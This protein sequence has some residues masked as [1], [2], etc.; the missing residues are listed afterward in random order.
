[1][2]DEL[3]KMIHNLFPYGRKE[4]DDTGK[5]KTLKKE[6]WFMLILCG[7]LLVV[8]AIPK[9]HLP[10][11]HKQIGL[12]QNEKIESIE[13]K[14]E[15]MEESESINYTEKMEREVEEVLG[16]MAGVGDIKV[17]ITL[18]ASTE[19]IIEKDQPVNRSHTAEKDSE[20][21]TRSL[22]TVEMGDT[23]VYVKENGQEKPYVVKVIQPQVEGVVV[24][25]QGAGSGSVNR[26]ITEAMQVLFGIEAHKVKVLK[27]KTS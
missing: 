3:G 11:S 13:E 2:S 24:L 8:L 18:M 23:T 26:N 14:K 15:L 5:R 20:G 17:M 27:M 12:E 21:G 25:A 16:Q 1:M 6:Q 10:S 4:Q 19:K 9:T 22:N 7:I